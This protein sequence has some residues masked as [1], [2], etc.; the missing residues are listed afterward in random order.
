MNV[1]HVLPSGMAVEKALVER[2]NSD[3]TLGPSMQWS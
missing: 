1:S 2:T 3:V